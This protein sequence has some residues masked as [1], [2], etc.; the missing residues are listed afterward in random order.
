MCDTMCSGAKNVWAR[1]GSVNRG[2]SMEQS[3]ATVKAFLGSA[4]AYMCFVLEP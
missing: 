2:L 4:S 1:K 3:I